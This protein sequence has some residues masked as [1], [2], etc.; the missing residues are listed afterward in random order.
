MSS[1]PGRG[2]SYALVKCS[3][4]SVLDNNIESFFIK[5]RNWHS[6]TLG[7]SIMALRAT[8]DEFALPASSQIFPILS[9]RGMVP[10][11]GYSPTRACEAPF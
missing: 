1:D 6:I 4:E 7:L 2:K 11:L 9:F 8:L 5:D 3:T 10:S